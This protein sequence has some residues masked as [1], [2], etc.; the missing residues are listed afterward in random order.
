MTRLDQTI[1]SQVLDDVLD[2]AFVDRWPWMRFM[3]ADQQSPRLVA[4]GRRT[5]G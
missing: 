2:A 4:V 5:R 1:A 3:Q